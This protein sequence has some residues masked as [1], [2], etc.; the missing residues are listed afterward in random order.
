MG[1][2]D[3]NRLRGAMRCWGEIAF[4]LVFC[5]VLYLTPARATGLAFSSVKISGTNLV[6]S[7][8][9]GV[10]GTTYYILTTTNLALSPVALWNRISTNVFSND[11]RFTNSSPINSSLRE[12]FFVFTTNMPITIPGLVAA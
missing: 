1:K 10:A 4:V 3:L 2:S 5:L 12:A 11:G 6:V 9:G 7:G 8:S